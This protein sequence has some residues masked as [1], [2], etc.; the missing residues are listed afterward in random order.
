LAHGGLHSHGASHEI[1]FIPYQG[2][3]EQTVLFS[4][5][6]FYFITSLFIIPTL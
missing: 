6:Y 2:L 4:D 1:G 5:A 3:D